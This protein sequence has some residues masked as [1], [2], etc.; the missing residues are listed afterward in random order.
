MDI[1]TLTSFLAWCLAI[2]LGLYILSI[3]FV[4]VFKDFTMS[5]H[6]KFFDLDDAYLSKAYFEFM[7][8]YKMIIIFFNLVPYLV[9]RLAL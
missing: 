8:R 4:T 6:K 7:G 3:I 5:L 1:T 9:L 2:N